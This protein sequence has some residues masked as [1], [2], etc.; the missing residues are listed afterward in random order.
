MRACIYFKSVKSFLWHTTTKHSQNKR[1]TLNYYCG[2][3]VCLCACME[4]KYTKIKL[5]SLFHEFSSSILKFLLCAVHIHV[6]LP[7][8]VRA[9]VCVCIGPRPYCYWCLYRYP[10]FH[11]SE[12]IHPHY[13]ILSPFSLSLSRSRAP[14]VCVR[15]SH[16]LANCPSTVTNYIDTDVC[17]TLS[18]HN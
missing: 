13:F 2:T 11:L 14:C 9:C 17:I 5:F 7:R 6:H 15:A 4:Q 10:A 18:S 8:S 12:P 3:F 1:K 16:G